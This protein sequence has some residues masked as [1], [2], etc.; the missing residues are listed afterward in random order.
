MVSA[1]AS[2]VAVAYVTRF[3]GT[4]QC[5]LLTIFLV[6]FPLLE[7]E[8]SC[9]ITI[10]QIIDIF[11]EQLMMDKL[12]R[13]RNMGSATR[14]GHER[15]SSFGLWFHYV[16]NKDNYSVIFR[17]SRSLSAWFSKENW[18]IGMTFPDL[19]N[20]FLGFVQIIS[21]MCFVRWFKEIRK[22]LRPP[23]LQKLS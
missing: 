15:A 7:S 6:R 3:I 16:N 4:H 14:Q 1:S 2:Q 18:A 17:E 22:Y 9:L 12:L 21:L 8:N 19:H 10:T 13:R 11:Y 5:A 23:P 20:S